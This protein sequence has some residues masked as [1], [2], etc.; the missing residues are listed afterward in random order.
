MA[1]RLFCFVGQSNHEQNQAIHN[2]SYWIRETWWQYKRFHW[3]AF[4]LQKYQFYFGYCISPLRNHC[5]QWTVQSEEYLEK[6][7]SKYWIR[8]KNLFMKLNYSFWEYR[9]ETYRTFF[10]NDTPFS[11]SSVVF[12]SVC[13]PLKFLGRAVLEFSNITPILPWAL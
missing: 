5:V 7:F 4:W 3:T 1:H 8:K 9:L 11:V 2:Y 12:F 6:S 13:A 10:G